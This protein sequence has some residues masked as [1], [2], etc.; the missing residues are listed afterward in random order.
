[1][2]TVREFDGLALSSR[3]ARLSPDER[4]IAPT[5]FRALSE[6]QRLV[7]GG[8]RRTS[9]VKSAVLE[10]LENQPGIR[11]EYVEIVDPRMQP[12]ESVVRDVRLMAAIWAGATRLIDNVRLAA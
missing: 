4:A 9:R 2:P 3:N 8:E 12:V 7:A 1:M 10:I 11:V 6:G 5:L